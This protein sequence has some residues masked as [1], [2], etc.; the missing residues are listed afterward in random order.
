MLQG[1]TSIGITSAYDAAKFI[2]EQWPEDADGPKLALCK[3]ILL[4]CLAGAR[5]G[6]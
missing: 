4:K 5:A 3:A 1:G 2:L 6:R